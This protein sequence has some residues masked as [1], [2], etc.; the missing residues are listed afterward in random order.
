MECRLGGVSDF[1]LKPDAAR[2]AS[3]AVDADA[4]A[5]LEMMRCRHIAGA[6]ADFCRG[7]TRCAGTAR[8]RVSE[9]V[10]VSQKAKT[11]LLY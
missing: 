8:G 7:S 1:S 10:N 9:F 4:E 3:A 5:G 6:R 11:S 2:Y